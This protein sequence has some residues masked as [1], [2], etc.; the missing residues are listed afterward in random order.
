MTEIIIKSSII[1]RHHSSNKKPASGRDEKE[2][3]SCHQPVGQE[4][5]T[6]ATISRLEQVLQ[7][8]IPVA[9]VVIIVTHDG[10]RDQNRGESA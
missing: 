9:Q 4:V 6:V 2:K 10:S 1:K 8:K 3:R 7:L 5:H